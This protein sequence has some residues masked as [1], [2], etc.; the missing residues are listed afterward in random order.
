MKNNKFNIQVKKD[1]YSNS[2][3]SLERF[4]SY[5]YQ[6]KSILKL[7]PSSILEIGIGNKTTSTYLKNQGIKVTTCDFDKN[8]NPDF[9]ADIRNLPFKETKFDLVACFE[10]LEHIPFE[11]VPLAMK[12]ISK[13]TKKYAIISV[14][15]ASIYIEIL[16]RFPLI[17]KILKRPYIRLFP[18]IPLYSKLFLNKEHFWELGRKGYPRKK[19]RKIFRKNFIIKKE[20]RPANDTYHYYFILKKKTAIKH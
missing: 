16:I 6:I 4:I 18:Y 14:P 11:D 8:L 13:A 20:F 3:D 5:Y 10:I 2:Y 19:L 9:I 17:K 15:Y 12:N 1:H 7:K